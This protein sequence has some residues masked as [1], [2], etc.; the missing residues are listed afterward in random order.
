MP[1]PSERRRIR[2]L[3]AQ[4]TNEGFAKMIPVVLEILEPYCG[5][6]ITRLI[7][8]D[9]ALIARVRGG[10]REALGFGS[11]HPN[12][13]KFFVDQHCGGVA[14]GH[15]AGAEGSGIAIGP[16]TL[17]EDGHIVVDIAWCRSVIN[18]LS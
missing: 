16:E 9:P 11:V 10:V 18:R 8:R 15:G 5:S 13:E 3:K 1:S 14:I 6:A 7:S 4:A 17:A 2:R 12:Q